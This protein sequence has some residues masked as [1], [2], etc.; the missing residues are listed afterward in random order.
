MRIKFI[1]DILNRKILFYIKG[2]YQVNKLVDLKD[3]IEY[4]LYYLDTSNTFN[5]FQRTHQTY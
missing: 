2:N 4:L 1:K 5:T 3:E